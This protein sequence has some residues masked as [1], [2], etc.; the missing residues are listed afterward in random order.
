MQFVLTNM[1]SAEQ[2]LEKFVSQLFS[3]FLFSAYSS[4]IEQI[5]IRDLGTLSLQKILRRSEAKNEVSKYIYKLGL[6]VCII[7]LI[8]G[9]LQ[10]NTIYYKR[11]IFGI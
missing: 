10:Y 5:T 11:Y 2:A 4:A 3:D 6:V 8:Y 1:L 7:D 9:I